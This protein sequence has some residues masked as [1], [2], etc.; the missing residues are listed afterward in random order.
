MNIQKLK[1]MLEE[2][3]VFKISDTFQGINECQSLF[4]HYTPWTMH[5]CSHLLFL[6]VMIDLIYILQGQFTNTESNFEVKRLE[7]HKLK[8]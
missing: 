3:V 2:I 7:I 5:T 4:R 1:E 6:F 8:V